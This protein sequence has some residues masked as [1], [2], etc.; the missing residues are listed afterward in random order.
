V[1]VDSIG[2]VGTYTSLAV[3]NGSPAISYY[4]EENTSLKW[5]TIGP[6]AEIVVTQASALTDGAGSVAFGTVTVGSSAQLTFT[7]TN[8]GTA[9]LTSLAV[10]KD[11]ADNAAF[12]VSALS[13]TTVPVGPGTATFT[14]TFSPGAGGTSNAGIHIASNVTGAKNPF[15]IAL[16]GIGQTVFES[17]ALAYSVP[18]DPDA[19]GTNGIKNLLNFA[20]GVNPNT[21]SSGPLVYNG[22]LAGGGTITA[23]GQPTTLFESIPTGVDFRALFVRRD[24]YVAAGL[25]YTVQFSPDLIDWT[26]SMVDPTVLADNGPHQIVSVPFPGFL[27]GKKARFFRVQVTISP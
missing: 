9:A 10:T 11:G 21:G 2:S 3:V 23:T 14:V 18:N 5:A 13:A 25:T 4:D 16:T 15:D 26:P 12:T 20:F 24:D 8:P 17:W 19:L 7:I 1:T 22:T 6:Y 27:S